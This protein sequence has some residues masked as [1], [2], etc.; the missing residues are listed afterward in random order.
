M[1]SLDLPGCAVIGVGT[2]RR[3]PSR[4]RYLSIKRGL[5]ELTSSRRG[6]TL[7][8]S[9]P[10]GQI[11]LVY[12]V[13]DESGSMNP[14]ID[15]LN[16]G[17]LTLQAALQREPWA[18]GKVRFSVIG[19]SQTAFTY[20]EPADMRF[21]EGE[22]QPLTA[23]ST[24]S[25][26]AAF[27]EL[28]YRLSVDVPML[29]QQG[30]IVNRPAAFFLTDGKPTGHEDWRAARSRVLAGP[31][32]PNILAFGI[33]DADEHIVRELATRHDY[34]WMSMHGRDIAAALEEFFG[35]LTQSVISSGQA[36][37]GGSAELQFE[38]PEGFKMTVDLDD[39]EQR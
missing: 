24:T 19:F 38:R 27:D 33:G 21:L 22:M 9:D 15:D 29:K 5:Q 30:Y 12:L 2:S 14:H 8:G 34:A 23:Q 36:V 18:A 13:A 1:S 7:V 10:R 35:S 31:D 17:L 6:E 25:Y 4:Q 11:L 32:R 37:G 20:L 16:E 26:S 39:D 3:M 28:G